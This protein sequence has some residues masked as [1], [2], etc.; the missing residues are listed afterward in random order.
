VKAERIDEDEE[1]EEEDGRDEAAPAEAAEAV[2]TEVRRDA[3]P[4]AETTPSSS[5]R[6]FCPGAGT[7]SPT[8]LLL[9]ALLALRT[10]S[11]LSATS[12]ATALPRRAASKALADQ[13]GRGARASPQAARA[14]RARPMPPVPGV[15]GEAPSA[16][17][18]S[19]TASTE[20]RRAA[21]H[22]AAAPSTVRGA[23]RRGTRRE[24]PRKGVSRACY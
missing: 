2:E 9:A 8:T 1:D 3:A 19:G 13:S 16:P 6:R 14:T 7:A 5:R 24:R 4:N 18:W 17:R 21:S 15:G 20:A 10:P 12:S 11:T 22:A 23:S